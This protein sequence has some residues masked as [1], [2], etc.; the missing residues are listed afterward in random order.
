MGLSLLSLLRME[1]Q[2]HVELRALPDCWC[3]EIAA[4]MAEILQYDGDSEFMEIENGQKG[5]S[6]TQPKAVEKSKKS[7]YVSLTMISGFLCANI[8]I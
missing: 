1:M 5:T 3:V 2:G 8:I 4:N 7:I 6:V